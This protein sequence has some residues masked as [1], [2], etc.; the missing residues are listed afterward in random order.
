ML[1][2]LGEEYQKRGLTINTNKSK[3]IVVGNTCRYILLEW[4]LVE[5]VDLY[6]HLHVMI[7]K[8]RTCVTEIQIRTGQGKQVMRQLHCTLWSSQLRPET[9]INI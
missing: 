9:K 4:E 6:K 7:I 8:D 3:Y 1:R 2:K 5:A